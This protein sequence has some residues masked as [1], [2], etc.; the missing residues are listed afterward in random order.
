MILRRAARDLR[1]LGPR[2]VLLVLAIAMAAG[3]GGGASL[4]FTNVQGALDSYYSKYHLADVEMSLWNLRPRSELLA[5]AK[6][7]GA[8]RASTRLVFPGKIRTGKAASSALV[9]GMPVKAPLD[10]LQMLEGKGLAQ[11]GKHGV[12]IEKD[13]AR[14]HHLSIGSRVKLQVEGSTTKA[15][16]EGIGR[17]PDS[18]FASADPQYFVLQRG[19]LAYVYV[20]LSKV[21]RAVSPFAGPDRVDQ[22]LVDLPPGHLSSGERVLTRGLPVEQVVPKNQQPGYRGTRL[23]LSEL[24]SFTPVLTTVLA[25]VAILLIAVTMMRLVQNQR[26]ELGTMLALGHKRS[27][28]VLTAIL[29]GLA[30]GLIGGVLAIPACVGVAKLM[31]NQFSSSY[32]FLEVPARLTLGAAAL[33]FGL[34]VV[35]SL[36]S[37]IFPALAL[38]RLAPA[39]ALRG[40]APSSQRLP[41]W[42]R[43]ATGT[44]GTAWAYGLRNVLRT[45]VRSTLTVLSLGGAIGLGIS[46]HIVASS[47]Q[48]TNDAWFSQQSWTQTGILQEPLP[49]AAA[50]R[51]AEKAHARRT[52]P[53]VS[54]SVQL[55]DGSGRLGNVNVVGLPRAPQLQSVGLPPGGI[56][57]GTAYVSKQLATQFDLKTGQH[58]ELIGPQG[59][60]S[61][62]IVG[63]ANT[64]AEQD[65]YLPLGAAQSVL[66]QDGKIT[67]LLVEG[68]HR[69]ATALRRSLDVSKVVSKESLKSGIG[70]VIEQLTLLMN[71]VVGIGLAVGAL[72]LIS[73]LAM[74]VLERQGEFAV[75][76]ALGWGMRDLAT[77]IA[78]ESLALTACGG[79][80]GSLISPAIASPLMDKINSA[81]FHI[82]YD[83]QATNFLV[84]IGPALLLGLIV[85]LQ[86]SSRIAR[87]DV[88]RAVRTRVAG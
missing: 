51:V 69:T 85:A 30:L 68:D 11:L 48:A 18:L 47:V 7:A 33:A 3:T 88:G 63:T 45:P 53:I 57:R 24:A 58:L 29:P 77:V 14:V 64:I 55:A 12:V 13:F 83:L 56:R 16:V 23:N 2:A 22:L 36:V 50:V 52:E 74:S 79:I 1:A 76:R 61:V 28:V 5:R 84:V 41:K 31:A 39:E 70:Y 59:P 6:R 60:T 35:T 46:L 78:V 43:A 66:G 37:V 65:A 75:L 21:Q 73:T 34:A 42:A 87:L 17:T 86:T 25:A 38:S 10:Q 8:T 32:G 71:T 72:F 9:V 4:T 80:V 62:V 67:S 27:T 81:W 49:E 82:G 40:D 44:A 26:R 20:P 15:R 19:S 54:G